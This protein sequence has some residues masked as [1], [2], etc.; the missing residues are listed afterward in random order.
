MVQAI[1]RQS[2]P[3]YLGNI[4]K[5]TLKNLWTLPS[6][7]L[8]KQSS[9]C[10]EDTDPVREARLFRLRS[11]DLEPDFSPCQER[12]CSSGFSASWQISRH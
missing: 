6:L 9:C 7:F 5:L 3:A 4:V 2:D 8:C 10:R 11:K 12:W 1:F